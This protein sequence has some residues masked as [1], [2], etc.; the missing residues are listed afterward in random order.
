MNSLLFTCDQHAGASFDPARRYRYRLW[1]R[2]DL[3]KAPAIFLM[4]NPSTADE[5][6]LDPTLR[7]CVGFAR[8]W[9]F[10][11][12]EIL[13]LFA[14]RSTDPEA[15]YSAADPIGPDNDRT[16]R[17]LASI[18]DQVVVAWGTHGAFMNRAQHVLGILRETECH[19]VC[20]GQT[21]DGHPKHPLYLRSDTERRD[22]E[23]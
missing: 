10:G 9:G 14:L 3:L 19:V 8:S 13:N 23:D 16:I 21:K 15:L 7:R 4:L 22:L 6:V 12:I 2:W 20:L 5:E 17:G 18:A 1:R 11:G